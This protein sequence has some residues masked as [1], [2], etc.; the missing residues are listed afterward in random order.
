MRALRELSYLAF[1]KR[2]N[3]Q[4]FSVHQHAMAE[5][6]NYLP[7]VV[8]LTKNLSLYLACLKTNVIESKGQICPLAV[9][10]LM[11]FP[12]ELEYKNILK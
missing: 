11:T 4:C 7:H 12:P 10:L 5:D 2:N 8:Q 3:V 1:N 9:I 6:N